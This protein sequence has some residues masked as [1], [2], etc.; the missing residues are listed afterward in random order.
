MAGCA[1][2]LPAMVGKAPAVKDG[3][4]RPAPGGETRPVSGAAGEQAPGVVPVPNLPP[5]VVEPGEA[6][7]RFR[8]M[9]NPH[10]D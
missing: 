6:R 3:R 5:E 9:I 2:C 10:D 7:I 8:R 1:V 4:K